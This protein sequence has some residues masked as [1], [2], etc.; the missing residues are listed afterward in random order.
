[1]RREQTVMIDVPSSARLVI[2][3][4]GL[5]VTIQ[6]DLIDPSTELEV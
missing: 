3:G 1:M 6:T 4:G 5:V 2:I